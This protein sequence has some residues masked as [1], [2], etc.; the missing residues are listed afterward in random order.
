MNKKVVNLFGIPVE[1][2]TMSEALDQVDEAIQTKTPLQIG[3]INAA[4]VVNMDKDPSLREAV[5]SS[6][7]ILADGAAV[8]W[9]SRL[10]R[11]PLPERVAGIDIMFGMFERGNERGYRVYCL[12][13][14]EEISKTVEENIAR[15]YP[16]LTLAGRHHGYYSEDEAQSV[17]DAVK[18][19]KADILL[20]AMTSPKKE[21]FLAKWMAYMDVPVCHGVGGSFDVYAGKVERAP[22]SWQKLGLEWLYRVKQEPGRLW[23]RYLFTNLSFIWLLTKSLLGFKKAVTS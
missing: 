21:R 14:T 13:A 23:K 9:A 2:L 12:G 3:V 15:D 10:L 17:A 1:A 8:V 22:E 7:I 5:L 16:G 18:N 20:V 4:K 6:D 19:S 11:T